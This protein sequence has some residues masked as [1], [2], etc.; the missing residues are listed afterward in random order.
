M[1]FR[2]LITEKYIAIILSIARRGLAKSS[3]LKRK[4][5]LLSSQEICLERSSPGDV[6]HCLSQDH[7]PKTTHYPLLQRAVLKDNGKKERKILR[8][9]Y[10]IKK[11]GKGKDGFYV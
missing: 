8:F 3:D 10:T 1:P 11:I 5:Q 9:R 6:N 2:C 4:M 7:L